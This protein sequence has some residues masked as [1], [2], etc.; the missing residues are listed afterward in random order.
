MTKRTVYS[1]CHYCMCLCGTRITVENNK[2][3]SIEPDRDNPFSWRDFCRKGKTAAQVVDHPRRIK[4]PLKRVGERYVPASYEEAESDIAQ[5]L[6]RI[7][8]RHGPDAV[9]SYSGNPLGFNF[10]GS[11]FW[12]GLLDAIGTRNRF[13][14]GSVDQNNTHVVMEQMYGTEMLAL[15]PDVDHADCFVLVGMDP[16]QSKFVWVETV[17][18]GWN[19]VL[20]AQR[21]GA[22]LIVVDPRRSTTAEAANTHV[23]IL[24]G[25]DWAFLLGVLHVLFAE[26]LQRSITAVPLKGVDEI[27]ALA[28][29]ASLDDL[30]DRCGVPAETIRDVA[31]RFGRAQRGM[32]LTHTGVSHTPTG[33]LAEWLGAAINAVTDRLDRPGGKRVERGYLD[34]AQIWS[35][36]APPVKHRTRLRDN[37]TIAGFHSLAELADEITTPGEGQIRAMLIAAGN[38]VVSGPDGAALDRAF[39]QLELLVAIDLVQRESHRHAHWL[40]PGTHFLEREGLHPLFA[41]LTE[42]PFAQYARQAVKPPTGVK[43]EWQFF[44]DLALRM[45]RNLFGKPGVNAFIRASRWL[46]RMTGNPEHAMNPRWIERLLVMSGRRLKYDDI[47]KHEHGWLYGEKEYGHF[48]KALRTPDKS[49]HCAPPKFLWALQQTLAERSTRT[50][51]EYPMLLINRR[52]RESMNSWLNETEG[53]FAQQRYNVAEL[54]PDDAMGLGIVDGEWVRIHSPAGQIELPVRIVP[55]GRAGVVTVPHGWGSAIY[56]P[57]NNDAPVRLGANR[58]LLIDRHEIDPFSQTPAL[59]AKPVRIERISPGLGPRADATTQALRV[60][61]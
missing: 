2:V 3:L 14:V 6:L 42:L 26:K 52:V 34:L 60:E 23:A 55:G 24:P 48:A 57:V 54:H 50:R 59:N 40:I 31:R 51:A 16:A 25:T 12:N 44:M 35:K 47:R 4:T 8:E 43:E 36:F 37:P 11:I 29:S 15:I 30:A 22:D 46:A 10:S 49:V 7:I 33:T 5:R 61:A 28:L 21:R 9:G 41:G 1:F 58:N 39:A 53:L 56:D 27:R 19:R 20:A 38:P 13:W 18:D 17:P 32:C 45:D